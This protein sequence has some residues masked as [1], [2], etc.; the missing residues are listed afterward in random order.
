MYTLCSVESL[1]VRLYLSMHA[2][3]LQESI[4]PLDNQLNSLELGGAYNTGLFCKYRGR[5]EER[6]GTLHV[7]LLWCVY[8][9]YKMHIFITLQPF[10]ALCY[11]FRTRHLDIVGLGL[12]TCLDS[13]PS[14]ACGFIAQPAAAAL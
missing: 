3:L 1:T 12:W 14:P 2:I 10:M 5:R 7:T 11:S 6:Q 9:W 4:G 13:P 8:V